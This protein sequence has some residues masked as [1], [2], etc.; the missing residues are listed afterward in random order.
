MPLPKRPMSHRDNSLIIGG[1]RFQDLADDD[2]PVEFPNTPAL[3]I[4]VGKAGRHY[5]EQTHDEG[6]MVK[7]KVFPGSSD[8]QQCL[9]WRAQTYADSLEAPLSGSYYDAANRKTYQLSGGRFV[10]CPAASVPGQTFEASFDFE[11]I[12]SS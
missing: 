10:S 1:Y 6:G 12:V 3:K 7:V 2:P 9:A 5:R 11:R 8:V 4:K